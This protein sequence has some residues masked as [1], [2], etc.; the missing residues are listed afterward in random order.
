MKE[1]SQNNLSVINGKRPERERE[2]IQLLFTGTQD[3]IEQKL[4]QLEPK[5]RVNLISANLPPVER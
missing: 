4:D 1:T 2:L 3:E 5:G